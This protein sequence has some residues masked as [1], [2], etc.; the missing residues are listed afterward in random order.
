MKW[1][2]EQRR[3]YLKFSWN[4]VAEES[5]SKTSSQA[6]L[7]SPCSV[8]SSGERPRDL[9]KLEPIVYFSSDLVSR[10]DDRIKSLHF[11]IRKDSL[12][13]DAFRLW[14]QSS[15]RGRFQSATQRFVDCISD[16]RRRFRRWRSWHRP[17]AI[18]AFSENG[19][20]YFRPSVFEY[21][22]LKSIFPFSE[23]KCL[24]TRATCS[25]DITILQF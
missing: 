5:S 16:W 6:R 8:S 23:L 2:L 21:T 19:K 22:S 11:K 10:F 9:L 13:I 7:T 1:E 4:Q 20:N 14:P 18:A 25:S 15:D 3:E 24:L 17:K 12:A